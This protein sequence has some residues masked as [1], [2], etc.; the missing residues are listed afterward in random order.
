MGLLY[1]FFTKPFTAFRLKKERG[2][3]G[4]W[5]GVVVKVLRY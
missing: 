3:F 1:L 5:G 2:Y 4:V